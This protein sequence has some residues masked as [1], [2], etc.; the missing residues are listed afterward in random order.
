MVT[1]PGYSAYF[2]GP[3]NV[4]AAKVALMNRVNQI[5]EDD[6]TIRMQFVASNDLST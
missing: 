2:G 6:L 5:Y 1:D 3:A 4:T